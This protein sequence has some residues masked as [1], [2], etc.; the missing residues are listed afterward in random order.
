MWGIVRVKKLLN[1]QKMG[2]FKEIWGQSSHYIDATHKREELAHKQTA[3]E[4]MEWIKQGGRWVALYKTIGRWITQGGRG[5]A[6]NK[7]IGRRDTRP[8]NTRF[9]WQQKRVTR[10]TEGWE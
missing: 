10:D 9:I 8:L 7:I 4:L 5:G 1:L 2:N 6:L 3:S